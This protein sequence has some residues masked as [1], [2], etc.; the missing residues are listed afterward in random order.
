[1]ADNATCVVGLL[2]PVRAYVAECGLRF[3]EQV[4]LSQYL[5]WVLVNQEPWRFTRTFFTD[6]KG[7]DMISMSKI[8]QLLIVGFCLSGIFATT[9]SAAEA[10]MQKQIE[11]RSRL[12]G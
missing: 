10:D 5:K 9:V 12:I 11:S 6:I 1:M 7:D 3:W 8:A 2:V 4:I